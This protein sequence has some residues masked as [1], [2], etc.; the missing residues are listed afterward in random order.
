[1]ISDA[2]QRPLAGRPTG[3][4]LWLTNRPPRWLNA[5][6]HVMVEATLDVELQM[7]GL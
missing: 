5:R 4:S 1:M 6:L 3:V 2:Q 7:M